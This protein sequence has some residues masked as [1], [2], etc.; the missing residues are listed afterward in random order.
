MTIE[1]KLKMKFLFHSYN[2]PQTFSK[3][4]NG[5]QIYFTIY[6]DKYKT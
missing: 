3:V 4:L 6:T 5:V 2:R 1:K